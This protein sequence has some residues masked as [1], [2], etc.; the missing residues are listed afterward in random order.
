MTTLPRCPF[1]GC[2]IRYRGGPDR[3]CPD[4]Q[5]DNTGWTDRL[6]ELQDSMLAA[7]GDQAVDD[8]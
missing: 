4:H 7:P 5:A 2:P 8:A 1:P 3:P 6:A